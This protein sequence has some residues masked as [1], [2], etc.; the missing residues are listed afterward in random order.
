MLRTIW[1]NQ[2]EDILV[3]L[4]CA[5]GVTHLKMGSNVHDEL[6]S[7]YLEVYMKYT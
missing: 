5:H 6:I 7:K 4:P 3:I 2:K 1:S